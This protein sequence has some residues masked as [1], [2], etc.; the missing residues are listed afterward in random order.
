[1][2]IIQA[3]LISQNTKNVINRVERNHTFIELKIHI[4]TH[5]FICPLFTLPPLLL[6]DG[7]YRHLRLLP[8]D[9]MRLFCM[10]MSVSLSVC[11]P[12]TFV[13]CIQ[14]AKDIVK[15]FL[16]LVAPLFYF[17]CFLLQAPIPNSNTLQQGR[18]VAYTLHSS[19][20]SVYRNTEPIS[21]I[22]KYRYR[23]RRRYSQYRKIPNIDN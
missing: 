19:L 13:Y 14:K 5:I 17:F 23:H 4:K 12:V 15:L 2:W 11:P 10:P 20:G 22:L 6:I 3:Y 8:R 21:D 1:M 16:G 7:M 18:K 9:A